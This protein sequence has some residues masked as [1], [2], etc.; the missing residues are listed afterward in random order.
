MVLAC[1]IFMNSAVIILNSNTELNQLPPNIVVVFIA[2]NFKNVT[3]SELHG[4][5]IFV[6]FK[7]CLSVH[8]D[9]YTIIV[10]TKCTSFY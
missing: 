6:D 1:I 5:N 10:P 4:L 7:C 9:N 8:V 2:P 3:F